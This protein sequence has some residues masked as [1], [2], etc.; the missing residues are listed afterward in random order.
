MGFAN[1]ANKLWFACAFP[2]ALAGKERQ[3]LVLAGDADRCRMH[4][5]QMMASNRQMKRRSHHSGDIT[6]ARCN[7]WSENHEAKT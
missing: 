3:Y 6:C 7:A 5:S 2:D 4:A 1:L